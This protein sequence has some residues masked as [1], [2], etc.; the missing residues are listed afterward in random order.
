MIYDLEDTIR[1]P[2]IQVVE[3]FRDKLSALSPYLPNIEKIETLERSEEGNTINLINKWYGKVILPPVLHKIIKVDKLDWTDYATWHVPEN[4]VVYRLEF[5]G[6]EQIAFV[7]GE[8]SFAADGLNT[9]VRYSGHVVLNLSQKIGIPELL[10][11]SLGTQISKMI[12][13]LVKPNMLKANR[14]VEKLLKCKIE[15]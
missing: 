1:C 10:S 13:T 11:Q 14:G 7:N 3:I 12:L 4:R 6:F 15:I 5:D 8:T 2:I 9:R